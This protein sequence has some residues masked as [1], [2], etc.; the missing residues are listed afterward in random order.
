[1]TNIMLPTVIAY[2]LYSVPESPD[3][4]TLK[5]CI[6][7]SGCDLNILCFNA[8]YFAQDIELSSR[9]NIK[10]LLYAILIYYF[11]Y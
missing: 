7:C 5:S 3:C 9:D 1:M 2:V 11:I 6:Y 8:E 4:V 10:S